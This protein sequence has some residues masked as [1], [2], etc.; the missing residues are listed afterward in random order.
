MALGRGMGGQ[1]A[2]V[3][4]SKLFREH[5]VGGASFRLMHHGYQRSLWTRYRQCGSKPTSTLKRINGK[6]Y[7]DSIGGALRVTRLDALCLP[8]DLTAALSLSR[9]CNSRSFCWYI[10][11]NTRGLTAFSSLVSGS[12][13]PCHRG[14]CFPPHS[15]CQKLRQS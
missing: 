3:R 14:G 10:P 8:A 7:P 5:C 11:F 12:P 15:A 4:F 2:R 13:I 1:P 6:G 9:K